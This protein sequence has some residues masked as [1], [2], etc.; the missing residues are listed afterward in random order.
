VARG[1]TTGEDLA[2]LSD[3]RALIGGDDRRLSRDGIGGGIC[4]GED[5]GGSEEAKDE[6]EWACEPMVSPSREPSHLDLLHLLLNA[7]LIR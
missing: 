6:K 4:G 1:A 7:Y 5:S 3:Q 2:P